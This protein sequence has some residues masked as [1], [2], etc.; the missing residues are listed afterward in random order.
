MQIRQED[1]TYLDQSKLRV[2]HLS[3]IV[4]RLAEDWE[5]PNMHSEVADRVSTLPDQMTK[6]VSLITVAES[7]DEIA[8]A[9]IALIDFDNAVMEI[10]RLD[11]IQN[12][13]PSTRSRLVSVR[14]K[15]LGLCQLLDKVLDE[16]YGETTKL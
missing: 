4:D 15:S 8:L 16:K 2:A 1:L 13:L 11:A 5:A 7:F 14:E 9:R 12:D 3:G 10:V 6:V